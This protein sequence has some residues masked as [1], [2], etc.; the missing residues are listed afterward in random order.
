[1]VVK[2]T[3]TMATTP[4]AA[5]S[6]SAK[7][8]V[9]PSLQECVA[10]FGEADGPTLHAGGYWPIERAREAR[11]A[12]TKLAAAPARAAATIPKP[13]APVAKLVRQ[14]KPVPSRT[15]PVGSRELAAA[16]YVDFGQAAS[17]CEPAA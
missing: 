14:T 13:A 1:M 15:A 16:I 6:Y 5:W 4:G 11:K 7:K 3:D 17:E 9:K 10:E 12:G 2:N 8:W